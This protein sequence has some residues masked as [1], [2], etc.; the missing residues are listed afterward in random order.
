LHFLQDECHQAG[1]PLNPVQLDA[2][3][4]YAEELAKWSK[5]MNLV[6]KTGMESMLRD[7]FLDSL[8]LYP[9][10]DDS[11][12]SLLD[13]GT[14]AGFPGLVLGA[15]CPELEVT[16]VEPRAKRVSFLRHIS[17]TLKLTNIQII[18]TRLQTGM[19]LGCFDGVTSRA[20]A[21]LSVF[22]PLVEEYLADD[23]AVFCMKGPKGEEEFAKF[24]QENPESGLRLKQK[25][26]AIYPLGE[27]GRCLMIF[28][29][30]KHD[31]H[32]TSA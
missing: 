4:L 2:L 26:K 31:Y 12:S 27:H 22:L 13:V 30:R 9:F 8:C 20:F 18:P 32:S 15:V 16:L 7:H 1:L 23:G 24:Q 3:C 10:M 28:K 21:D 5:K 29:K 19:D 11:C 17:R 6:A 25:V 14:G